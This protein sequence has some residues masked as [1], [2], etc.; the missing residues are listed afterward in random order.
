MRKFVLMIRANNG[1]AEDSKAPSA[2]AK[3]LCIPHDQEQ[4]GPFPDGEAQ[5]CVA[6]GQKAKSWTL[7]GRSEFGAGRAIDGGLTV[8]LLSE[9]LSK[10]TRQ[11]VGGGM[12]AG[13]GRYLGEG[14]NWVQSSLASFM[15][16]MKALTAHRGRQESKCQL[17][18][19]IASPGS[20]HDCIL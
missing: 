3:S 16:R 11:V 5:K 7:F 13:A 1:V 6:C 10:V 4:Y 9:E 19:E 12:A 8:R 15:H 17:R 14:H 18:Y 2:G 20:G